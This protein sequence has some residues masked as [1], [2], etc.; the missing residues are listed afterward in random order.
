MR[1]LDLPSIEELTSLAP[2]K[3]VSEDELDH[4]LE[5]MQRREYDSGE[6]VI[7]ESE[8]GENFYILCNGQL[9]VTKQIEAD[10]E[11]VLNII[12][13][14]GEL[15]GEMSLVEDK[16][17]SAAV[18]A[19]STSEVLS[20]S[21]EGFLSLVNKF[22]HFTLAVARSISNY[23]RETDKTLIAALEEKNRRLEATITELEETRQA[24][25]D[26]ER[27][28]MI[29]R[30]AATIIHDLKNPMTTIGGFAQLLQ[31][32][33]PAR[34]EVKDFASMINRQVEQFSAT[35]QELLTY[36]KGSTETE[37]VEHALTPVLQESLMGISFA[38][39]Q[40]KMKLV[41][42]FTYEGALKL[43]KSRFPRIIENLASNAMDAM[44]EGGTVTVSSRLAGDQVEIRVADDGPGM[45]PEIMSL[46][47]QEFF[48]HGKDRGTGLGLAITQ[49]ITEEHQGEISVESSP[50]EGTV[51]TILFPV[52]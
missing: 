49:T 11:E 47:F 39:A 12:R 20:I 45:D 25:V 5:L 31:L 26:S 37:L 24:L 46:I 51:F 52:P 9:K 50:G 27:L 23:L 2:F 38:L 43:D 17:R 3:G 36:A 33:D 42:E 7:A 44:S 4:I 34:E 16:P 32:K 35:A 22:P 21:K 19:E 13:R 10:Q 1:V 18:V 14:S 15:F 28:S 48:T 41:T 6:T 30:M 8:L 29:G 40:K